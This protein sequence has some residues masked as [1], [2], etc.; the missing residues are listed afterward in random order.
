MHRDAKED[1]DSLEVLRSGR[2]YGKGRKSP[3]AKTPTHTYCIHIHRLR[4]ILY[5]DKHII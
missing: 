4:Y 1:V 2:E 3:I 5:S